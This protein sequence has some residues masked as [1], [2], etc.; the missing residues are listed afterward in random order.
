MWVVARGVQ[1]R[2]PGRAPATDADALGRDRLPPH[3]GNWDSSWSKARL[4]LLWQRDLARYAVRS[5]RFES[6]RPSPA[7]RPDRT[8]LLT[9]LHPAL[10]RVVRCFDVRP[11][12]VSIPGT[13]RS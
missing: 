12:D 7:C 3:R 2:L 10:V 9:R 1:R 6:A 4:R 5:P 11:R 8:R 13:A